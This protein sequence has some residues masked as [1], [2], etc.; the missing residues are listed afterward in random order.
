MSQLWG[1][2]VVGGASGTSA[3]SLWSKSTL[4]R[5]RATSLI[6]NSSSLGPYRRPIPRVLGGSKGG[7]AFFYL[8]GTPV[9]FLLPSQEA[10]LNAQTHKPLF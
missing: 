4:L 2:G 5:Y 6:R 8:R 7:G 10:P 3:G 1:V 9:F